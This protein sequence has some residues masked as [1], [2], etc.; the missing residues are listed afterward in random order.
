MFIYSVK[1]EI[2][3]FHVVVVNDGKEMYSQ[4]HVIDFILLIYKYPTVFVCLF[5]C[6]LFL[7]LLLLFVVLVTNAVVVA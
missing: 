6:F 3:K 1:R 4:N 2:R 7:L 5:V